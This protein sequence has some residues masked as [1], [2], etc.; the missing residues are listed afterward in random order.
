V[1][2]LRQTTRSAFTL[3]ELL[4]VIAIIALLIAILLP[5]LSAARASGQSAKCLANLRSLGTMTQCYLDSND[6]F[7]PVRN[8][9]ALGGGNLFNSFLPTRTIMHQ[10]RR[11]LDIL[12]CPADDDAVRLYPAGDGTS[13]FPDTLGIGD[14]YNLTPDAPVRIS[15]G[16]NNM[17]GIDPTTDAE[18]LLFNSCAGKYPRPAETLLYADSAYFN[19]RP[20]N[21]TL[22][23]EPR[24]KGRVPNASAP[25]RMNS[26]PAIPAEYGVVQPSMRRHR[27][28]S[29]VLFMDLHGTMVGQ[30]DCFARI[31]HS[32]TERFGT[33]TAATPEP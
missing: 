19:I 14:D 21:L 5:S 6:G 7:F 18:R 4:V 8:N 17:T 24:L 1:I 31:L 12:L 30:Q 26:L 22:N 3:I 2:S 33:E 23:D 28:G 20:S 9:A 16:I 15:L 29:N 25:S 27:S 32:W 11:P 10:D 13:A